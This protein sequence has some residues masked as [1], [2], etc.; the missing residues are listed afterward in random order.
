LI[1]IEISHLPTGNRRGRLLKWKGKHAH[2]HDQGIL[3]RDL[4]PENILVTPAGAPKIIDFGLAKAL[5]AEQAPGM[6]LYTGGESWLGTP[7]YAAPEQLNA[8]EIQ[9]D[10]RADVFPLGAIFYHLLT[11]L[12][13]GDAR[14]MAALLDSPPPPSE[15][16]L[17]R[18]DSGLDAITLHALEPDRK[19]R[20]S[21]CGRW[22]QIF[23][24][25][26]M[27]TYSRYPSHL[28]NLTKRQSS[29]WAASFASAASAG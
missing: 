5:D 20:T 12:N 9:I 11:G 22:L 1:F 6:T 8:S 10:E 17:Q 27:A 24:V 14:E 26:S 18:I 15:I 29:A 21:M 13:P 23:G 16:A 4:K 3:H 25:I 2:A 19:D 7:G 28:K